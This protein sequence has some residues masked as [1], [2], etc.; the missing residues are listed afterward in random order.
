M[1]AR[2]QRAL[3]AALCF[4]GLDIAEGGC[5]GAASVFRRHAALDEL[6][7]PHLEVESDLVGNVA[8][9]VSEAEG[10]LHGQLRTAAAETARARL[11]ARECSTQ[12]EVSAR[13]SRRP[14]AVRV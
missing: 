11:T 2:A 12:R 6:A 13:S 14:A 8:P 7:R 9:A 3:I 1:A 10:S 5:G 4:D